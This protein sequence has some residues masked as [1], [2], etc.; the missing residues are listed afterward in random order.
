M[1]CIKP[2]L[3]LPIIGLF[4]PCYYNCFAI[5]TLATPTMQFQPQKSQPDGLISQAFKP[6]KRKGP[7]V[8]AGGSTRSTSSTCIR[9]KQ[10]I[11]P[12]LPLNKLGLTLAERPRLFWYL[13]QTSVK[14]A[15]FL[16]L[17]DTDQTVIHETTFTLPNRP[18]IFSYTLPESAPPLKIG[19]TYHWYLTM[20]CDPEDF[21]ANPKVEG[22]VERIQPE[23]SLSE[24]LA[25]A[26]KRKLA[27]LYA[28]AGIWHEALTAIAQLHYGEPRNWR[29][30]LSWRQFLTSVDLNAIA[31][32]PLLD[33]CQAENS[34]SK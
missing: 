22:W 28:E 29:Y 8:S 10:K 5:A 32:E 6:P 2:S 21:S 33:C 13:P 15:K 24:Q 11:T 14:T 26:D 34:A 30:Q 20:V 17:A 18:G 3:Y 16:L 1:K 4:L 19:K 27:Y 23:S 9:D 25:T 12:L 31:A 7:P